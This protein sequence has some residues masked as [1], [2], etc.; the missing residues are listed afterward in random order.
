MTHFLQ[1]SA[2]ILLATTSLCAGPADART[3][4]HTTHKS[5]PPI[6][7]NGKVVGVA[8]ERGAYVVK[9]GDTLEKIAAKLD[10]TVEDLMALNGLKSSAIQPGDVLKGPR[11]AKK[12]YVVVHGD[13]VFSIA[14]R[15]HVTVDDLRAANGLTPKTQIRAGQ[16]LQIPGG[17]GPAPAVDKLDDAPPA[18]SQRGRN[19]AAPAPDIADQ[20]PASNGRSVTGRVVNVEG[21]GAPYKVKKGDT[22]E[23]IA[24][25]LD[26]DVDS[27]KDD[28]HLKTSAIHP[29][30][31]LRG[32]GISVKAYVVGADDTLPEISQRFGVSVERLR[33]ANGLSRRAALKPG[34]KLRLPSGYRDHGPLQAT[35]PAVTSERP[36]RTY[37]RPAEPSRDEAIPTQR[38]TE[39]PSRPQPYQPTG[40]PPPVVPSGTPAPTDAQVSQMGKG[41]FQWP[42]KG[43][44]VSE[45]G[46]KDGGQRNDGINIRADSG[47]PVRSAADGDVVYAGDQVPG[48]GNLVLIKHADGW[49]TA[50]GHLS[51]VEVKMQQKV[52]QGQEIGQAGATGGVPEPQLHFEV[53]YAPNPLERA[54][55]I[56]PKLVLP[57]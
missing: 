42:I 49:V 28:N 14:K 47:A 41:R 56:D 34:Q 10:T 18:K 48:F 8:G 45:F 46:P 36:T 16:K 39:T 20:A 54:R 13:T 43:D 29:G 52:S 12:A 37:S 51:R 6:A 38:G 21:P 3:Q 4:K 25:K 11:T 35:E 24:R 23:R 2:L 33:A 44:V 57:K 7:A 5:S 27:L 17:E 22:L 30:Q 15:F 55:P 19:A 50:Y 31:V 9:K 26:T 1:R 53:R 40:A 32:P